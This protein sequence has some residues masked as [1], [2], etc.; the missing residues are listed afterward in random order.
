MHDKS[1]CRATPKL[2]SRNRN[3]PRSYR[4]CPLTLAR[5]WRAL[6]AEARAILR[7]G[8]YGVAECP[9]NTSRDGDVPLAGRVPATVRVRLRRAVTHR[10]AA[11]A[12]EAASMPSVTVRTSRPPTTSASRLSR[13]QQYIQPACGAPYSIGTRRSSGRNL[14]TSGF[15][16]HSA[17]CASPFRK[18][19]SSLQPA[20]VGTRCS[21]RM[22]TRIHMYTS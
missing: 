15:G 1:T 17:R 11:S 5:T 2:R 6:R 14:R 3:Q 18:T 22:R 19:T 8:E 10:I 16:S 21:F 20:V 4:Y 7:F 13:R 9:A 12:V